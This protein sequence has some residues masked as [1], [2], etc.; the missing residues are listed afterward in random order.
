[1]IYTEH[2]FISRMLVVR[3]VS[4]LVLLIVAL[5]GCGSSSESDTSDSDVGSASLPSLT[6]GLMP[7]VDTAPFYVAQEAGYFADEGVAVDFQLFTSGQDRQSALQTGQ[8][9]GAMTDLVAVAVNVAGGFD[10]KATMLTEGVFPVMVHPDSVQDGDA[11]V[12]IGLMEVSVTNFLAD[13]WL[14]E[15]YELE[16]V[17]INQVPAR[18]EALA[19]GQLDMGVFPEPIASIGASRGLERR[20]FEPVD[21]FSP[22]VIAFTGGAR[23]R[24]RAAIVAFQR[25][26]NRAA[27]DI[28]T[29]EDVARDAI[30]AN[31]PNVPPEIRGE[32]VLPTYHDARLPDDAAVQRII[33]WTE[34]VVDGELGVSAADLL[35]RSFVGPTGN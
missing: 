33:A 6:V 30:I 25:A 2:T 21:G 22:D 26:Y 35:D 5:A 9:D 23:E 34:Q 3:T 12:S 13:Q 18:L 24:K 11:R 20:V 28:R 1:M 14:G 27:A 7:A 10:L 4:L 32:I 19:S 31:I 8:I 16:K 29:R 17:F 15:D